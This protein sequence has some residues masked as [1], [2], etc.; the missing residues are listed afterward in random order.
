MGVEI[1]PPAVP[2]MRRLTMI[3]TVFFALNACIAAWLAWQ[4]SLAEWTLYNGC[5]SY[6]LIGLLVVVE[7]LYRPIYKRRHGVE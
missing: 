7:Y 3:W 4:G 6:L 1:P 2:Y 5:I